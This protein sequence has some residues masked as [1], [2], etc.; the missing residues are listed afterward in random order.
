MA[1][2][3]LA[4]QTT[5]NVYSRASYANDGDILT[6]S[7]TYY[8][9]KDWWQVDLLKDFN[10]SHISISFMDIN[11]Y[12]NLSIHSR[13][14]NSNEWVLC[15]NILPP[16]TEKITTTCNNS[17]RYI[18]ISLNETQKEAILRLAEVEIYDKA[19]GE[20]KTILK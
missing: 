10:I 9:K 17:A 2:N 13:K 4:I 15:A 14:N 19:V 11:H 5:N 3:Q 12:Q 8:G 1:L 18:R 16:K 7:E 6:L 20:T